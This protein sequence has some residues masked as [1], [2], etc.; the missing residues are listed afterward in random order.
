V[1][2]D[3]SSSVSVRRKAA[4]SAEALQASATLLAC[5]A[6]GAVIDR[7]HPPSNSLRRMR[8]SNRD[9]RGAVL[10]TVADSM[11]GPSQPSAAREGSQP[12]RRAV[13]AGQCLSS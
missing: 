2:A 1:L 6:I 11:S 4:E 5:D 3:G 7:T 12:A 9:T 13:R 10:I 8:T